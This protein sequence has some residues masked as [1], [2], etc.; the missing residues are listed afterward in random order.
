[1]PAGGSSSSKKSIEI[2][3]GIFVPDV[4]ASGS[5]S[6]KKSWGDDGNDAILNMIAEE[7]ENAYLYDDTGKTSVLFHI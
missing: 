3:P 5:S 2:A 6:S 4:P 7:V 1:M